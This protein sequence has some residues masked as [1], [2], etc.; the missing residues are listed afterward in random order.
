MGA[1][2]DA[3]RP[4]PRPRPDP[5]AVTFRRGRR[6]PAPGARPDRRDPRIGSEDEWISTRDPRA[7]GSRPDRGE[8]VLPLDTSAF[9]T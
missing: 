1:V 6:R 2:R 7:W 5:D 9:R 3:G 4:F 8:V